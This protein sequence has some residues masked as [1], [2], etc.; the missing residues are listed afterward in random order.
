MSGPATDV[1]EQTPVTRP[2][3]APSTLC[4][5]PV[6]TDRALV[7]AIVNRTPDSFYD[8]GATFEDDMALAAVDRAVAEGADLVDIGGVKA[9]PGEVVDSDEE[10]RRVV[11]FVAAIRERYPDVLIS[12]DTWRSEVARRAVGEG[13][14]LINDTWAGA[15]PELV[16]VA[17]EL[18]AGIVC[19]HTGGAV[20]R[21]RPHRVRYTDVVGEVVR[22]VVAAADAAARAGVASDSILIDPT[23][24]FGKNTHHGLALL[25]HVDV[26]VK[27]GWPVLMA[28]SNKDFVGETLG[29]ELA[30]RLEGTLAATAL[31]AAAG[32]RMFRVHEVAATRRVVD[33]VAAIA[34]TRP[35]ARTVRGLA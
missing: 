13:A 19:S 2:G 12:V 34:G 6:A 4:G 25:R 22:E 3:P 17:A 5:R 21:T 33:M 30:D 20:P 23:H 8:R 14:D 29:V 15:D 16:A 32:A 10:I 27:T 24:D 9:G 7:M 31:A 1:D 28:L 18:G 11:P 35:P 26:L